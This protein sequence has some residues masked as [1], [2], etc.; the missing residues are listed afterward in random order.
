M[1]SVIIIIC[2]IGYIL[3]V[4]LPIGAITYLAHRA[5]GA[6]RDRLKEQ[7][8]WSLKK[9]DLSEDLEFIRKEKEEKEGN[10]RE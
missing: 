3:K 4:L 7:F 6:P 5:Y 1:A 9:W 10:D 2:A 8:Y